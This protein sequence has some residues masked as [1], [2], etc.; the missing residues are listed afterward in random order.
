[1]A[2]M[3]AA[4]I[5]SDH[6]E[7]VTLIERDRYPD[8]ATPRKGVPQARHTHVLL[9]RGLEIIEK[10]FPGTGI[11]L[12]EA[13]AHPT[14]A[15]ADIKWLTPAGWSVRFK[16]G[17][18]YMT[19]SRDLIDWQVRRRLKEIE[20]IH[21]LQ[22]C[23]VTGLLT[24]ADRRVVTGVKIRQ[25]GETAREDVFMADLVVDAGGRSSRAP[26]WLE[27]LGYAPPHETVV[28]AHLG[29]AS[30]L[31]RRPQGYGADWKGLYVQAAPPDRTRAGLI[32]PLE[33]DRILVTLGGGDSDYPPTDEPGFME[34]A[35][36]LA[37]PLVY[38]TIQNAEP[39]SPIYGHRATENRMRHY[40][41]MAD[42]PDR[43]L[44]MGDAACAFNPVYGQGMTTAARGAMLL[45]Q[46]LR[47][48]R[49]RSLRGLARRFQRRLAKINEV[50]WLLA[51]GEDCRYRGTKGVQT[52]RMTRFMHGYV[53][54]VVSLSTE[55]P[56]VRKSLLEV[57]HLIKPP[58]A[59]F[60]P[61]IIL[62]ALRQRFQPAK[63]EET[64]AQREPALK[65][66]DPTR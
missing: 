54:R 5:L 28:N 3:L 6:F 9:V 40:D 13:G 1:M 37:S 22:E 12:L 63:Q 34:F 48:N 7:C 52:R 43:F 42:Q 60:H 61:S 59:L 2:G 23:D 24:D 56:D 32:I 10:L 39:I 26:Q 21:I 55:Y 49:D 19:C 25:R 31:Y 46:C 44:V 58:S 30:R 65:S 53:N 18:N 51:T 15:A 35:R 41:R 47:E 64:P 29:Y 62:R 14:D 66:P 8:T 20:N 33:D 38:E 36:S 4:R 27:A 16:S 57:F 50:P 17:L 45:D 11:E